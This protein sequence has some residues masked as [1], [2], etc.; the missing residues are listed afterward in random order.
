METQISDRSVFKFGLPIGFDRIRWKPSGTSW[1]C[2]P[3]NAGLPIGFDRI[4]WK[5][6]I[7]RLAVDLQCGAYRLASIGFTIGC[8]NVQ[9]I[10]FSLGCDSHSEGFANDLR[11]I[12]GME[13][14]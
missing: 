8:A 5:P 2:V 13:G 6:E 4:R 12:L 9:A 10:V 3:T 11:S 14:R 7:V 1:F